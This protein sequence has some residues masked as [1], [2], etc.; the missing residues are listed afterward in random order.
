MKRPVTVLLGIA[1][2]VVV[3]VVVFRMTRGH[4]EESLTAVAPGSPAKT[5]KISSGEAVDLAAFAQPQGY[6]VFEFMAPW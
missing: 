6:T 3:G 4:S 1:A 2:L 5:G